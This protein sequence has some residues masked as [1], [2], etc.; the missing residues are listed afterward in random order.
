MPQPIG[1]QLPLPHIF[2]HATRTDHTFDHSPVLP[3]LNLRQPSPAASFRAQSSDRQ[4]EPPQSYDQLKQ[5]N[6]T[7]KTRISELEV[8][9]DLYRSRVAEL[10]ANE[11]RLRSMEAQLR[12]DLERVRQDEAHY[13]KRAYELEHEISQKQ[14]ERPT[15]RSRLSDVLSP[16]DAP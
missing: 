16:E 9:N 10:E 14:E 15:K 3:A 4:L 8:I 13:R 12:Q 6:T 1:I 2:D 7:Y 11:Q 5:T